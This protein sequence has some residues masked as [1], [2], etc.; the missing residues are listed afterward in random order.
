MDK[1]EAEVS[2][3]PVV[4]EAIDSYAKYYAEHHKLGMSIRSDMRY[5]AEVA[6][7]RAT[8]TDKIT[9]VHRGFDYLGNNINE[10]HVIVRFAHD[11]WDGRDAFAKAL[12][13]PSPK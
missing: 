6:T 11:D 7:R 4:Q 9:S 3:H 8:P 2:L 10:P 5:V 12:A 13:M 1:P